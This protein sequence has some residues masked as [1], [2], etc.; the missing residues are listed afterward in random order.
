VLVLS[1]IAFATACER[2]PDE[3]ERVAVANS[4]MPSLPS[5]LL[6]VLERM[7]CHGKCPSYVV[8]IDARGSVTWKG[9]GDVELVGE[10]Q[11]Q[12]APASLA[13]LVAR[14]EE[15]SF[16]E[17]LSDYFVSFGDAPPESSRAV[18]TLRRGGGTKRVSVFGAEGFTREGL[19]Q[20]PTLNAKDAD[21]ARIS[22]EGAPKETTVA[23]ARV[24][25]SLHELAADI[26]EIAGT[27][28]WIGSAPKRRHR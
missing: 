26:D 10:G 16:E 9:S 4:E 20:L 12:V 3:P 19:H 6:I 21:G 23:L 13:E 27:A 28:R 24:F 2:S 17:L 22:S 15:L 18:I 11:A 5:D 1:T 7:P 14:F 25:A 8:T